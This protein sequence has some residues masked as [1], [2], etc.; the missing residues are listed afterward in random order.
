MFLYLWL[1]LTNVPFSELREQKVYEALCQ[2]IP[3]L[4]NHLLEAGSNENI[5]HIADLVGF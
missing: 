3:G 4:Q 1:E 2:F 5:L